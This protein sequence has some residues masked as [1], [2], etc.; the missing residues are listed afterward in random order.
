MMKKNGGLDI[1]KSLCYKCRVKKIEKKWGIASIATII[2]LLLAIVIGPLDMFYS[3]YYCITDMAPEDIDGEDYTGIIVMDKE[4]YRSTFIPQKKHLQGLKLNF[5][6]VPEGS[7]GI[8]YIS[9]LNE[10]GKKLIESQI[11]V[12]VIEPQVW[13]QIKLPVNLKVGKTYY[14]EI[15]PYECTYIPYMQTVK[16]EYLS[17]E[18]TGENVLMEFVYANSTF[19]LPQKIIMI[20]FLIIGWMLIIGKIFLGGERLKRHQTVLI[21][22]GLILLMTLNYTYNFMDNKNETFDEFQADSE[23]LV[24]G[25]MYAKRDGILNSKY[26]LVNYSDNSGVV[27]SYNTAELSFITDENWL[28]GY[29]RTESKIIIRESSLRKQY[30]KIGNYILFE[31]GDMYKITDLEVVPGDI[32]HGNYII[33]TLEHSGPLNYYK[34]GE[35]QNAHYSD[36]KGNIFPNS[37]YTE[38]K[39]QYGLQGKVFTLLAKLTG[40]YENRE[41]FEALCGFATATVLMLIV[42]LI[43]YKYNRIMAGCFYMSFLL[44]PWIVNFARNLYWVEAL[45]FLPM[46]IGLFCSCFIKKRNCR[47]ISYFMAYFSLLIKCLCGYEY[48]TTIMLSM[49]SFLVVDFL[50]LIIEDKNNKKLIKQIFS[51]IFLLGVFA[52]LGFAT[53]IG[54]HGYLRGE[55]NVLLGMQ[56]IIEQDAIRRTVGDALKWPINASIWDVLCKYFHFSTEIITGIS[57]NLF[58]LLSMATVA[59]LVLAGKN[60]QNIKEDVLLF[61][62]F[63]LTTISWF[64]LAKGHSDAH[65]HMNYVLWYFGYIQIIFY[66]LLKYIY[67]FIKRKRY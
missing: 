36:G 30:C 51:S 11:D 55:G 60:G 35:L 41:N 66:I 33:I 9:I 63:F 39:S 29:S 19:S 27:N 58:P 22:I 15:I 34:N 38:Y 67:F 8:L 16:Q 20:S 43:A 37:S 47:L 45:W 64:V 25:A 24:L 53:A 42:Y 18:N 54:I 1:F 5:I 52:I 14:Y 7:S 65:P 6:N 10:Q 59:T 17:A 31:N 12:S 46:L 4:G 62:V 50:K 32:K 3:G 2:L 61:T 28:N 40:N 56:D 26:G 23:T 48:I 57:G 13:Q 44:S 49:I 21:V